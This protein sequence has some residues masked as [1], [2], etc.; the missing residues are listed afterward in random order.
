MDWLNGIVAILKPDGIPVGTGFVV[1]SKGYIATSTHLLRLAGADTSRHSTVRIR[2]K[3][4]QTEMTAHVDPGWCSPFNE[5]D[6]TILF[7]TD[8]LPEG[9]EPLPL[10]ASRDTVDHKIRSWGYP[11]GNETEGWAGKGEILG[12]TKENGCRRLQ[13]SSKEITRGYSGGPLWDEL[14][15]GVIGVVKRGSGGI[16]RPQEAGLAVPSEALVALSKGELTLQTHQTT[17]PGFAPLAL[18]L[19]HIPQPGNLAPGSRMLMGLNPHFVG[20]E[21]ELR[22]VAQ[23]LQTGDTAAIGQMAT[24]TGLGGVGKSQLAIAF[25]HHYGAFFAGGV[26]WVNMSDGASVPAELAQC[27]TAMQIGDGYAGLSLEEQVQRVQRA[28]QEPIPRLLLFDNCEEESLLAQWRPTTGGCRVLATSRRAVWDS[29]LGVS[30]LALDTLTPPESRALL[31][32]LAPHLRDDD[33]NAIAEA[34]G[35]LPLALH[36]AGSYLHL[37]R[38]AP[39]AQPA[40]YLAELQTERLAHPSLQ[41]EGSSH[42]P[43]AHERHV[44]RTFALSLERLNRDEPVDQLALS[45]LARAACFAPGTPIPRPLL[46]TSTGITSDNRADQL[47]GE[48]AMTRLVG[49][50]LLTMSA[51]TG[52]LVMHRLVIA[53][54]QVQV[55]D[56]IAQ[57]DVEKTVDNQTSQ[58]NRSGFPQDL[59]PWQSHLRYITNQALMRRDEMAVRLANEMA[60]HLEDLAEYNEARILYEYALSISEE[61]LGREHPNTA[62]SL[63]NLASLMRNIG[64]YMIA[65]SLV[66][67]A[68]AIDEKNLGTNHPDVASDLNA[69]AVILSDIGDYTAARPLYERSLAI[70]ERALGPDHPDVAQSLNNLAGLLDNMGE[71]AAARPLYERTVAI[72]EKVLGPDH[73]NVATSLNNLAALLRNLGEYAAAR[74]LYERSLAIRERALGPDHPDVAQSLNNL[75]ELLRNLGEYAAARPLYERTVAIFEKVLGPDHPNVAASLNNLAE[76]LR[77]LGE[78]AAARP[79]YE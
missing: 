68:L 13:F 26:F 72:F 22:Q 58:I 7:V 70:R 36:L 24:I 55:K 54:V 15:Q 74:P 71:Y 51:E 2:F 14:W 20:R 17:K 44:G 77:N 60:Y 11:D 19:D 8:Q 49:L 33:A 56:L 1:S 75:A 27:G 43:T 39:F 16:A 45:L 10:V 18:P 46:L 65:R 50:G 48:K 31:Q 21:R 32:S 62:L 23:V 38:H 28:W 41:G 52:W 9:V 64:E 76:L 47:R 59:L 30:I 57:L 53:F 37:Y 3:A 73:P 69:L 4:T 35:H 78:Y 5:E 12:E 25:A 6:V 42:S 63:N 67:R 61:V 29:S 34:L 66:E 40:A 79:L